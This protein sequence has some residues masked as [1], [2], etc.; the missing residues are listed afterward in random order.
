MERE[1]R[2]ARLEGGVAVGKG[3]GA[4]AAVL[5]RSRPAPRVGACVPV[6]DL[7]ATTKEAG[8]SVSCV[9]CLLACAWENGS[10][11]DSDGIRPKLVS[12]PLFPGEEM[13]GLAAV[14]PTLWSCGGAT[15]DGEDGAIAIVAEV[16]ERNSTSSLRQL[17]LSCEA[18]T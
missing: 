16:W 3:S 6:A 12:V 4:A 8:F 2:G 17:V 7:G 9:S 5:G 15:V 11:L 18:A 10:S 13:A 1:R 14:V